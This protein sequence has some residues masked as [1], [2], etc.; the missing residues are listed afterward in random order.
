MV[1]VLFLLALEIDSGSSLLDCNLF[2]NLLVEAKPPISEP[3]LELANDLPV[4]S[5]SCVE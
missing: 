2:K 3:P 1:S 5:G 4:A